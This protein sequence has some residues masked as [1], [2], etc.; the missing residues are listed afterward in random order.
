MT[1]ETDDA[2]DAPGQVDDRQAMERI[3][4]EMA[5]LLRRMAEF[6][7]E[8]EPFLPLLAEPDEPPADESDQES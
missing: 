3:A 1:D 6:Q 5:E 8:M 2:D 4:A 7:R